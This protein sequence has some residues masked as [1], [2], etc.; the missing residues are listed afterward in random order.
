MA[1]WYI[2]WPF[3]IFCGHLEYFMAIWYIYFVAIL[4]SFSRFGML[5][6]EKIWQPWSAANNKNDYLNGANTIV[7]SVFI[8]IN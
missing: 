1:I 6:Q 7:N 4:V 5:Y 2:L 3:G 8:L